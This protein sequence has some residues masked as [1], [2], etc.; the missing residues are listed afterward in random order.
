MDK[1]SEIQ[2]INIWCKKKKSHETFK[3]NFIFWVWAETADVTCERAVNHNPEW[4][5]V[6]GYL[7]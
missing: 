2:E 3:I 6:S 7:P 5:S 4:S 1:I